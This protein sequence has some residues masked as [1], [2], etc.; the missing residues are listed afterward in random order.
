M[1]LWNETDFRNVTQN[2]RLLPFQVIYVGA[3]V[4]LL[5]FGNY[6]IL[7]YNAEKTKTSSFD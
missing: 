6:S 4:A 3:V 5:G 1:Q 2:V 7:N